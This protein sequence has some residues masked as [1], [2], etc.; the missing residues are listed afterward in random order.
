[1]CSLGSTARREL[2]TYT[3]V[4]V[5]NGGAL[6]PQLRAAAVDCAARAAAVRRGAAP[7]PPPAAAGERPACGN[8][9]GPGSTTG[10]GA[11]MQALANSLGRLSVVG[12][13]VV[14]QTG[15]PETFDYELNY[16]P[17]P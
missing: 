7:P 2:P 9:G 1:M 11:T 5:R 17:D 10:G 3:L 8:S 16:S 12:R 4:R 15:L 14:N 6:G 13:P